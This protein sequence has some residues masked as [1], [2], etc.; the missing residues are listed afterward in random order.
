MERS[1]KQKLNKDTVKLTKVMNHTDLTDIYRKFHSKE[2]EYTFFTAPSGTFSKTDHIIMWRP[3]RPA[4]KTQLPVLLKAGYSGSFFLQI[5]R[6]SGYKCFSPLKP[7]PRP[8]QSP[9][10]TSP[11]Q[12]GLLSQSGIKGGPSTKHGLVYCLE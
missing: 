11:H 2:K 3:T 7:Q 1:Q 6:L 4:S 8:H 9:Q 10:V 12:A 5:P